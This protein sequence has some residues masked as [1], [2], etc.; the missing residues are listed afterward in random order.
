MAGVI[1]CGDDNISWQSVTHVHVTDEVSS[2][3][4]HSSSC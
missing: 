2:S 4:S 3:R 1:Y